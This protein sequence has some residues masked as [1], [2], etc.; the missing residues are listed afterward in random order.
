MAAFYRARLFEFLGH[1]AEEVLGCLSGSHQHNELQ[2]RQIKAWQVEIPILKSVCAELIGR[3]PAAQDW[4]LLLEYPIPRRPKRLDAVLLAQDIIFCFE[5][6][7]RDRKHCLQTDRQAED[8]A[9]DLRDFHEA[10]HDRVIIPLAVVPQAEHQTIQAQRHA[11]AVREVIRCNASELTA[12]ILTTF[13]AEHKPNSEPI[14]PAAWDNS[15]YHPVPTII[16]AAEVLFAGH[17]VSE[18]AHAGAKNLKETSEKIVT[19][20]QQAQSNREKV[21]CFVTGVPGAGKTLAGLNVVHNPSLRKEGRPAGVFLSGNGPLV[22]I[23]KAALV[24]DHKRRTNESGS[25]RDVHFVDNVHSFIRDALEKPDKPAYE[26]VVIFDEAQRAWNA[27]QSRKKYDRD[28][29]EAETM[30]S[31]MERHQDWAVL[32]ALVG[33]GQEIHSGEAGLSEWGSTLRRRFPHWK[34]AV[35]PKALDRDAS[36]AGQTLFDGGDFGTLSVQT[37]KSLHLEVNMR[38]FRAR[39]LAD[40]V[41]AALAGDASSAAAVMPDLKEFPF[42]MTRSLSAARSWLRFRARGQQRAGLV[43]SS[44]ALRHRAEGLELSS[45]FRQGN[46]DMYIHWF[47]ALPPDIRS[48]NQLEV[49]ASEFE[50]QG[51]ELDWVGLCWGGDFSFDQQSGTWRHQCFSGSR[52]GHLRKEVDRRY[53]LN[54]YRVLLTRARRGLVIWVPQGDASDETRLPCFFD[55]TRSFLAKCGLPVI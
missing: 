52:W 9:V 50:C 3:D 25:E 55:G 23:V 54:T 28:V 13:Q 39:R 47:L 45:G 42:A 27:E 1:A 7:T 36:T 32:V 44:G 34:V 22:K 18:I 49:A 20:I 11:D 53:L 21:I 19:I 51:L 12:V 5:F 35:S 31:I 26:R 46:R 24:R 10:S 40:W 17:N 16:E 29:S 33:G 8:Y 37:E 15:A 38:T 48:S 30:L 6:K 14:E 43:A 2:K 41:E 4:S